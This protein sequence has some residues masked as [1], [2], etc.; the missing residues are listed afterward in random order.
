MDSHFL[1]Q[2]IFLTQRLN[3]GSPHCR[4]IV[5]H[6][7]HPY[8]QFHPLLFFHTISAG[9][10]MRKKANNVLVLWR[11]YFNSRDTLSLKGPEELSFEN[12]CFRLNRDQKATAGHLS[13][14]GVDQLHKRSCSSRNIALFLSVFLHQHCTYDQLKSPDL[15]YW[16]YCQASCLGGSR[17][18]LKTYISWWPHFGK[19]WVGGNGCHPSGDF[20]QMVERDG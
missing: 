9:I 11:K 7:S 13:A 16:T 2:G 1:L 17:K 5:Y 19:R 14:D 12:H 20:S 3:P 6:W 10:N 15:F 8:Q 18:L 4:Q